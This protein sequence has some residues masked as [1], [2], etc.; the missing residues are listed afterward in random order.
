VIITLEP[1]GPQY[2]VRWLR[3][4]L[5]ALLLLGAAFVAGGL[6]GLLVLGLDYLTGRL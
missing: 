3:V 6:A 2:R 1:K 5:L 4:L